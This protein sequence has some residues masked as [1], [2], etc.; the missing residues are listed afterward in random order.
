[1]GDDTNAAVHAGSSPRV[2]G[3]LPHRNPLKPN[4]RLIPACAGKTTAA[5][6][7]GSGRRAH[8]RVCGENALLN[9]ITLSASG[10]SPRVRG[11][12]SMVAM[13]SLT[14][15]LIPACA[16][17]TWT[18]FAFLVCLWAHPRVCGENKRGCR[19][20]PYRQGSSPRVRGKHHVPTVQ[21]LRPG[22]IPAC[23]GKTN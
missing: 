23:A 18:W 9:V 11:K 16:G 21:A 20:R 12:P 6:G 10:S 1:M 17:K 13:P 2:R 19:P 22:L 5:E 4:D 8:P 7:R 14:M 15:G 3:K